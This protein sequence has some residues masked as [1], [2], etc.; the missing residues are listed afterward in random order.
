[1]DALLEQDGPKAGVET[2]ETLLA[3]DLAEAR[4]K[5][6]GKGRLRDQA[7]AS[8]L[9]RAEGYIGEELGKGGRNTVHGDT[10]VSGILVADRVDR[11]LLEELIATEL[12][13][14]LQEVTGERRASAGEQG[15]GTFILDDLAEATD[16][17][18]VVGDRVELDTGL[19]SVQ[20]YVSVTSF[21]LFRCLSS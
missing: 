13:R 2:G 4:D 1:M 8:G 6:T 5:A 20:M 21:R 17:A 11:L 14:T 18:A 3:G 15:A 16:Q 19:D 12:Q 10:V 9:E 7:D